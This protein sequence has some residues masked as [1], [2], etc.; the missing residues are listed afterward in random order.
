MSGQQ[1]SADTTGLDEPPIRV[2]CGSR[3]ALRLA[4]YV[5]EAMN[6]F[7]EDLK[8][9]VPQ[10]EWQSWHLE[11]GTRE[12]KLLGNRMIGILREDAASR[13]TRGNATGMP[14]EPEYE[15]APWVRK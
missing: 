2:E 5:E 12:T 10:N 14:P 15:K 6:Q 11:A 3:T 7:L 13:D 1:I 9:F 4:D 8:E